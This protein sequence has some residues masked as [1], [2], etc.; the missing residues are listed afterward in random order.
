MFKRS[1]DI[2]SGW[3]KNTIFQSSYLEYMF[4]HWMALYML[5]GPD[6]KCSQYEDV[7]VQQLISCVWGIN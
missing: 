1:K 2:Y 4:N 5:S 7:T 6:Q 3:G